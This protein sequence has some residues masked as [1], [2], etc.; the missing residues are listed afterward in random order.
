MMA[1][2]T[3]RML[4]LQQGQNA[5]SASRAYVVHTT[6]IEVAL[7]KFIA[8]HRLRR[9]P[10]PHPFASANGC[11]ELAGLIRTQHFSFGHGREAG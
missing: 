3:S 5:T 10:P 1:V 11:G 9:P 2:S 6:L 7:I 4:L 8:D